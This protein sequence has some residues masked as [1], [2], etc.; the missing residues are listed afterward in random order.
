MCMC[1][2][3][4]VYMYMSICRYVDMRNV[5]MHACMHVCVHVSVCVCVSM[6]VHSM[7]TPQPACIHL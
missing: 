2:Y 6:K 4:Y 3:V 7:K 5:Y 1:M